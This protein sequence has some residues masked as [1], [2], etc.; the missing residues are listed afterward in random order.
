M[1]G[2]CIRNAPHAKE[3]RALP[4][5]VITSLRL[6]SSLTSLSHTRAQGLLNVHTLQISVQQ[7]QNV[8]Q[9]WV[10]VQIAVPRA[11]WRRVSEAEPGA[12]L[13]FILFQE[14]TIHL[15]QSDCVYYCLLIAFSLLDW[16]LELFGFNPNPQ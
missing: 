7:T 1:K 14:L 15:H 5:A 12:S 13:V 16:S 8:Q 6:A 4:D 10:S 11:L 2:R 9:W 3:L